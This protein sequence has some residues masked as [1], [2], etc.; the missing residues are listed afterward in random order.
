MPLAICRMRCFDGKLGRLYY[1][2]DVVEDMPKNHPL[3]SNFEFRKVSAPVVETIEE[4]KEI[5]EKPNED[6]KEE[7]RGPGRPK[8]E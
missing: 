4:P 1:I 6:S 7:K 8:K 5:E 2:G 3:A